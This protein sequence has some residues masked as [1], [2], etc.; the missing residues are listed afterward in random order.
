VFY[1]VLPSVAFLAFALCERTGAAPSQTGAMQWDFED[2]QAVGLHQGMGV[3]EVVPEPDVPTNHAYRITTDQPHHSRL[4]VEHS[5]QHDDFVLRFRARVINWDGAEPVIYVYGHSGKSGF[6]GLSVTRQLGRL[7]CYFGPD[8]PGATLGQTDGGYA[9]GNA[10]THV[11]FGCFGRWSMAK[12][13]TEGD[14]EPGWQAMGRND[15][16]REGTSALGVWTS[17][18]T[19]SKATVLF[20]DVSL[21]PITETD[22]AKL[23][24]HITPRM[25]LD[26]AALNQSTVV[27]QLPGRVVLS[28]GRTAV[29]FTRLSGEIS[30]LVDL[31][32]QREFI[33]PHHPSPLFRFVFRSPVNDRTQAVTSRDF[34]AVSIDPRP[35]RGLS[36]SFSDLPSSSVKAMVQ[37]TVQTDGVIALTF[38]LTGLQS[39]IVPRISF[40]ELPG[41]AATSSSDEMLLPWASGAVLREPGSVTVSRDA[42]YPGQ[43][44]AQFYTRCD[45]N[46][47]LYVGFHD[48]E[49]HCK[50]FQL[51]CGAGDMAS[52]SVEHLQPETAVA[53]LVLPY[54][55]VL[56]TFAGD[57]RDGADIYK[58]WAE[59]Q[60]WC[61]T[62]LSERSDIPAFLKEGAGILITGVAN[63]VGREKLLGGHLEKLPDLLDAYRN[64]T[65]LKH[66]VFVP[67]GW[68]NRGTWVGINYLPSIPSDGDWIKT[69][70]ELRRRGHRTAFMTSGFW[71][72]VKR[73]RTSGGPA[74]DD[75]SQ[76]ERMKD[77]CITERDGKTWEVDWY[78]RTKEFG[79]WRGLSVKLCHGSQPARDMLRDVFLGVVQLGVPLVS[80]D[81]EIGGGQKEP[82]FHPGHGHP[83]G[84]GNWAWTDFHDLCRE[85]IRE[86]KPIQ[87]E[88]GLFLENVSELAIPVM[89]TYWSRQFGEIDVGA[90]GA[91]GVG[92]FS[93]LYHEYVTAIGA[94]CVQGQGQLGTRPDALLR[95][96]ILANNLTRG[97]IPGPFMHEVPIEGLPVWQKISKWQA[98]VGAAYRSFSRPYKHFP[99]YLLLG[100]TVRPPD[101]DCEQVETYF[102][103]R[104][105]KG[106]PRKN[107]PPVSKH[108][109]SL[110]AVTAGT[111]EAG[112]GSH[113]TFVVNATPNEREAIVHFGSARETTVF[114]PS[115]EGIER[116]HG[117]DIA[118]VLP[119]FGIRV[120]IR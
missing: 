94:A 49:G 114:S 101:V 82:C 91:R 103:R 59:N 3:G 96:R 13:W 99:E 64:A 66:I 22:L 118:L 111:F 112:D 115:R 76:F 14:N 62:L 87:P 110:A 78:S 93:Y 61:D 89:S 69:N 9:S 50:R 58:A 16:L 67:Y 80:F 15:D 107:G 113:A 105:A 44:F 77:I 53:E 17:P 84:L 30:N 75:T 35:D 116:A 24:I 42:L 37:A 95:C 85:I 97:L 83:P 100:K 41:P 26:V 5:A 29:A 6:R 27:T 34:R 8:R 74:F 73:Q 109:L 55:S 47:G 90:F 108:A 88:L 46:A 38:R 18:R 40:P 56:K 36:V 106:K 104:D 21:V 4:T 102:W 12:V 23:G 65:G 39:T 92:L 2:G 71:W 7:F 45:G 117:K 52:M 63:P 86:G 25:P 11:A 20:D 1:R 51:R 120:L 10:W 81:Q 98:T 72:V 48:S 68:E 119:P 32:T 70:A 31:P 57:W 33:A 79:S 28:S 43:A 19:P 60:P 54:P